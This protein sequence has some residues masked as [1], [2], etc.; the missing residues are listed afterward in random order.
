MSL[1]ESL[2][3][4]VKYANFNITRLVDNAQNYHEKISMGEAKKIAQDCGLDLVCF[5]EPQDGQLALCKVIDY[6]KWKYQNEKDKKKQNKVNKKET[7]EIQFSPVIDTG[8]IQHK[9]K[10]ANEFLEE[11][12]DVVLVMKLHG[13][14]KVHHKEAEQKFNEII[15]MC[16]GKEVSRK[17]NEG[18]MIARLAKIVIK[19]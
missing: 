9:V 5:N 6:G 7:K 3:F 11:G 13:R 4:V 12:N 18:I 16:N 1:K 2:P 15:K 8:D 17:I 10:H 19:E 14:Q